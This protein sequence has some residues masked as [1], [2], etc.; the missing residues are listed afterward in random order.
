MSNPAPS[1]KALLAQATRLWPNRSKASDGIVPSAAHTAA[2]PTSDHEIGRAGYNHAVDLTHDPD[3]GCDCGKVAEALRR[4][5][6]SGDEWR[7]KYIIWNRRICSA[8]RGW[9]WRTYD[10]SNPHTKH[11]HMSII[12]T[13]GACESTGPWAIQEVAPVATMALTVTDLGNPLHRAALRGIAAKYGD[14]LIEAKNTVMAHASEGVNADAYLVY[15]DTHDL[16]CLSITEGDHTRMVVRSVGA[17]VTVDTEC[18]IRLRAAEAS[19][20]A[21]AAI[22]N[23]YGK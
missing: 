5:C 21:A 15:A 17:P 22:L 9:E 11:L 8:L 4:S 19:I 16:D 14:K 2:N 23:D 1:A 12:D 10:G 20:G 3:N 13:K 18:P 7:V 6:A